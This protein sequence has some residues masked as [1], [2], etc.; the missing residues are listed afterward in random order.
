MISQ[1]IKHIDQIIDGMPYFSQIYGLC[2]RKTHQ[3]KSQPVFYLNGEYNKLDLNQL[4]FTYW[5]QTGDTSL[6]D[7]PTFVSGRREYEITTPLRLFAITKRSEFPSDDAYS[8]HRLAATL[9]KAAT[10]KGGKA[11]KDEI[12]VR[13]LSTIATVY[14]TNS[15]Q[16]LSEEFTGIDWADFKQ[17][18]LAV[19]IDIDLTVLQQSECIVDPCDY[20]P[21][22]CLQLENYIALPE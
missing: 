14:S 20:V 22:F 9:L 5:R 2:E 4:G 11:L 15:Q 3:G 16:I 18:D 19:A 13:K 10:I 1:V 21:S 17:S 6:A 12:K 7:S 8:S